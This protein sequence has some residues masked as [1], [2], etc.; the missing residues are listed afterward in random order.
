MKKNKHR[1]KKK[2]RECRDTTHVEVQFNQFFFSTNT[3][4][5][6]SVY[7]VENGFMILTCKTHTVHIDF[8]TIKH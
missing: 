5:K 3:P 2:H 8:V 4:Y 6:Y 1:F 7:T